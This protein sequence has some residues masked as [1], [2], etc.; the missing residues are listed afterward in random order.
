MSEVGG[1][2]AQVI[3]DEPDDMATEAAV[4]NRLKAPKPSGSDASHDDGNKGRGDQPIK[5]D[6]KKPA[7]KRDNR[8][9]SGSHEGPLSH[10][11]GI[12]ATGQKSKYAINCISVQVAQ[13]TGRV[14]LLDSFELLK[15]DQKKADIFFHTDVTLKDNM[16]L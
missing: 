7:L 4:K 16:A 10:D 15:A 2:D 3:E 11:K 8:S 1:E 14:V 12:L 13:R 6:D 5:L 9:T